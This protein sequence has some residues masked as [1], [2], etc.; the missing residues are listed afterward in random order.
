[1]K[2]SIMLKQVNNTEEVLGG[3]ESSMGQA[4]NCI[5]D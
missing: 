3:V 5:T 1:M 2:N 4:R